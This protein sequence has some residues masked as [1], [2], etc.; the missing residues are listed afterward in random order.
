VQRRFSAHEAE[1]GKKP[2]KAENMVAMQ[3]ADENVIY[4]T[5]PDTGLPELHLRSFAAIDQK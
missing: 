4:L 3:V 5:E 2:V 1:C